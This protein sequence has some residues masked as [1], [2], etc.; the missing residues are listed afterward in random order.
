MARN[1]NGNREHLGAQVEREIRELITRHALSEGDPLPS[2]G[3][4]VAQFGVSKSTVREAIRR[5]ETLGYVNV[6]HGVGLRVGRF[7]IGSVVQN[8]PYDLL[9]KARGLRE[10]L[11]VRTVLEENFLVQASQKIS[12]DQLVA[13]EEIVDRMNEAST[14]G[15]VLPELDAEF[16]ARLYECLDNSLI[17]DLIHAFWQL[18][19]SA[20]NALEFTRNFH[21]VE[22]HRAIVKAMRMGDEQAIR[23]AMR[24]HFSQ[25]N[26]EL[27]RYFIE[28]NHG[29]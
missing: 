1:R 15:E 24:E 26:N 25:I 17:T 11:E 2:E 28:E 23:T 6:V 18:F 7:S 22:E 14:S 13:L 27:D 20:R 4:L 10:I 29:N 5:L 9:N 12:T 16:H 19:H 8:L 21:A 3:E